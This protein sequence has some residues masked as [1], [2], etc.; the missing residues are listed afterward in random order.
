MRRAAVL[1]ALGA[2]ALEDVDLGAAAERAREAASLCRL[3]GVR[4]ACGQAPVAGR[5]AAAVAGLVERFDI[6]P[7]SDFSAK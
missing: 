1:D 6:E 3:R 7:Y 2:T 5:A 4:A